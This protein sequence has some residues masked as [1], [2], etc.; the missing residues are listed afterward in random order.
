MKMGKIILRQIS[1]L[2]CP[3]FLKVGRGPRIFS[4]QLDIYIGEMPESS[5]G[6]VIGYPD[7]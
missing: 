7:T 5:L 4:L 6:Q 1:Y 2:F 3:V